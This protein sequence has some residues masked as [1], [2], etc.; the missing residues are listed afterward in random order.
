MPDSSKTTGRA[1]IS[2]LVTRARQ[3]PIRTVLL[4][5]LSFGTGVLFITSWRVT[6]PVWTWPPLLVGATVLGLL[7]SLG[8]AG[9][10]LPR[11]YGEFWETGAAGTFGAEAAFAVCAALAWGLLISTA[12]GTPA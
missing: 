12:F 8:I 1:W 3:R 9:T 10:S 11:K 7:A 6:M 2:A 4:G 5:L